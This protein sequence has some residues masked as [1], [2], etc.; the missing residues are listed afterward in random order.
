MDWKLPRELP[1]LKEASMISLD[2]ET[3]DPEIKEKGPGVR[4]D[5][6]IVGIAVG[7]PDGPRWYIPFRHEE[8]PQF[9][10]EKV[11]RWAE[12]ELCR[13]NQ[14]KLGANLLY[15]LDYL[16]HWGIPVTG[17]FYDVQVAEPLLDEN[18]KRYNLDSLSEAYL[19]EGKDE[20]LLEQVCESRGLKGA[21][22]GHI[23]MLP[24]KFVGP[25]AEADVDRPLR[26]FPLQ[27]KRL[28]EEG[29]WDLF[30]LETRLIPVLL[31]MRQRGVRI[32]VEKT[33]QT[34]HTV[35]QKIQDAKVALR[36]IAGRELNV[37]ANEDIAVAFENLGIE[38]KRTKKTD[39]PSFQGWWLEKLEHPIGK[40][41][42]EER[43]WDKFLSTFID[44]HILSNLV[45]DRVHCQFNALKGDDFG[46]V[47]GRM[48]SCLA[49]G[50]QIKLLSDIGSFFEDSIENVREGDNVLC[51]DDKD[52][53]RV[54]RVRWAGRTGYRRVIRLMARISGTPVLKTVYLTP[55]HL[56]RVPGDKYVRADDLKPGCIISAFRLAYRRDP[57]QTAI[58][59]E[60]SGE[61]TAVEVYDIQLDRYHNFFANNIA[62][63][64]SSPN[65]QQIPSRDQDLGP[66][67]RS[68]FIP[69][70]GEVWGRS[71]LSQIELRLL[72]H[73][74]IGP[75]ADEM[76]EAYKANPH[77]DFHQ[78]CADMANVDRKTSK[79]IN[80]GICYGMGVAKLCKQLGLGDVEGKALMNMYHAKLPFIKETTNVA[81]RTA[82]QRGYVH[83][84]LKRRRRFTD[85]EPS[86]FNLSW[87]FRDTDCPKD[88]ASVQAWIKEQVAKAKEAGER[89]PRPG[90]KRAFT[91][92]ALN[93]IIQGSAADL[94]KKGLV[95]I[96]ENGLCDTL[97]APLLL[98]HDEIDWSVPDTPEGRAAFAESCRLMEQA[99]PFRVPIIMEQELKRNWG[100]D[101]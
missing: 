26:I 24:P 59:E 98:V 94:F 97:G 69:E 25:Y 90:I 14:P 8:G 50:T 100:E 64:N 33:K 40:L 88:P 76:R 66:L 68:L 75:G 74:G 23:W 34:R 83:T 67:C 56:V 61:N 29:L 65:L 10:A 73:Y 77:I 38:Y 20:L 11:R 3:R 101:L 51:Y 57:D 4:R 13:P 63:H 28:E 96:W 17:P 9:E 53:L 12:V 60:V 86:D 54:E 93:A 6:Y 79:Q 49:K 32:D 71:D 2:I 36:G 70:P 41:I 21:P 7:V 46:T 22:Q 91:Y 45:G 85:W 47:T 43:K 19:G 92:R 95:D 81:S 80:F 82:N 78:Q 44:G 99:I 52:K 48:S 27:K 72:A 18:R 87:A 16:Y 37:W 15:D 62:V 39:A 55:E 89:A 31:A 5:G 30:M 35:W 1:C 58:V 42:L 84:I